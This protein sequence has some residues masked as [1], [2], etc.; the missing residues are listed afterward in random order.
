[1]ARPEARRRSDVQ[2]RSFSL[3]L[4]RD[5]P[6]ASVMLL[7]ASDVHLSAHRPHAV[8]AF[9]EFL[10]GPVRRADRLYLLGDVFDLWLG[11]D[12]DR[13][14]HPEVEAALAHT[15]SAGVPVDVI[16]GNH[17]FLL[18]EKFVERTGC[19]LVDE[20]RVIDAIGE[21]AVLL[22]G[23]TLCTRDVEYQAFRRYARDPRNQR[24][25]LARPIEERAQEAAAI[26]ATSNS[27]TRLKPEDIMDVTDAE[28]VRVLSGFGA[29]RM[30]HG[31]THRPAVHALDLQGAGATR[32]VLGDWYDRGKVL[33]WDEAGCRL[34]SPE[35]VP[36]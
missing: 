6:D 14:P 29:T 21:R 20:P 32:I 10:A 8:S 27:R 3:R 30:I 23:D 13:A 9:V 4:H 16:R 22:H 19:R 18:G 28:V 34:T 1:M 11:D 2:S 25:F 35:S 15:V 24:T 7:F 12:D 36:A 5:A 31:H 26:R 17:D 33:V